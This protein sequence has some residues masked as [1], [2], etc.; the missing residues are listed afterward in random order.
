MFS[1]FCDAPFPIEVLGERTTF[2][3]A[4]G[5]GDRDG[6]VFFAGMIGYG[7]GIRLYYE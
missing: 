4:A 2:L 7:M 6:M 5:E 3:V 1:F